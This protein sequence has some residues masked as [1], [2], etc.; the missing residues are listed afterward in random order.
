MSGSANFHAKV[1]PSGLERTRACHASVHLTEKHYLD[2]VV[3][4]LRQYKRLL[5]YLVNEV[6]EEEWSKAERKVVPI[7]REIF[8]KAAS[9]QGT[10]DERTIWH[11]EVKKLSPKVQTMIEQNAGSVAAREGT[12][13]HDFAEKILLGK[14]DPKDLP[15][16]FFDGVMAYVDHCREISA[17]DPDDAERIEFVIP[18]FYNKEA[19]CT[20]DFVK[21]LGDRDRVVIRDLKYGK[22]KFV[23][24][25]FNDQLATYAR[26]TVE[27][28]EEEDELVLHDGTIIDMGIV[29]PRNNE[30]E[31]GKEGDKYV[32][33]WE[34]SYRELKAFTDEI[35]KDTDAIAAGSMKFGPS[36]DVCRWCP[37][38]ELCQKSYYVAFDAIPGGAKEAG[39][40]FKALP[41]YKDHAKSVAAY[42]ALPPTERAEIQG[43]DTMD[44]DELVALWK[45]R[46][47]LVRMAEDLDDY[48][49]F[50]VEGGLE[51]PELKLV[52][53]RPPNPYIEDEEAFAAFL[54][55]KGFPKEEVFETKV[56]GITSARKLLG[57]SIKPLKRNIAAGVFDE[58]LKDEFEAHLSRK[59]PTPS[60]A[61]ISD[62]RKEIKKPVDFFQ[63]L[64]QSLPAADGKP[65]KP[66]DI[67]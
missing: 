46:K 51:H 31:A 21:I 61:L 66:Q 47:A 19:T 62:K 17:R 58:K 49:T 20:S 29:Q 57:E 22:G 9:R 67:T 55:D 60:L 53:G 38:K 15:N 36:E 13:A 52:D 40:F 12:R 35:Q 34:V 41:D 28:L 27:Y 50:L 11:D 63:D 59:S 16:E 26:S 48:L 44:I 25:E 14:M 65:P 7:V 37:V 2:V 4:S 64:D 45:A 8:R 54:L 56:V 23:K 32:R 24:A 1:S 10:P 3:N 33:T 5:P 30:G 43:F 6:P 42:E 39:D 18:I